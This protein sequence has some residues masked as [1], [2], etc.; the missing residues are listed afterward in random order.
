MGNNEFINEFLEGIQLPLPKDKF[1]QKR[2][3]IKDE[4][5]KINN[6][7]HDE[8]KLNLKEVGSKGARIASIVLKILSVP[9]NAAGVLNGSYLSIG[10]GLLLRAASKLFK[11]GSDERDK[12]ALY[13]NIIK[14]KHKLQEKMRTDKKNARLYEKN[15]NRIEVLIA[16]YE[17][18]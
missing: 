18:L 13:S 10:I 2:D 17:N 14:I 6:E 7:F 9:Y 15:L 8:D 1:S 4:L 12:E 5:T 3:I 16:R 11:I